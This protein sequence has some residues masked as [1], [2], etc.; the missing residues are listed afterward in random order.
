MIRCEAAEA[1]VLG[2][3]MLAG[4]RAC[5]ILADL[6]E[7]DF[8]VGKHQAVFAAIRRLLDDAVPVDP[9]TVLGELSRSGDLSPRTSG[10]VGVFLIDLIQLVPSVA[11]AGHYRRIVLEHAYR[12]R[13]RQAGERL[14]ECASTA[15]L[16]D[17]ADLN[18]AEHDALA[19][20]ARRVGITISSSNR[21]RRPV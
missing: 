10:H 5:E 2:A 1:V 6:A 16:N 13:V 11:N 20:A 18:A 14:A 17:L 21:L 3:A 9:V 7:D 8:A 4:H 12:R 15:T 19:V